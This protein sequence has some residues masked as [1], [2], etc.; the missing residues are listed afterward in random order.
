M[1]DTITEFATITEPNYPDSIECICGNDDSQ[2]GFMLC[3]EHGTPAYLI[4]G[5]VPEGFVRLKEEPHDGNFFACHVCGRVYSD[6]TIQSQNLA[7]VI[8]HLDEADLHE[9]Q[10]RYWRVNEF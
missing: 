5:P 8:L 4:S 3:D 10:D 9:K 6:H 7:P 2:D 1:T